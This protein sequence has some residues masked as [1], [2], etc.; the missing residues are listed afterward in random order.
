[1]PLFGSPLAAG[2]SRAEVL[3]RAN[4]QLELD[5]LRESD[6]ERPAERRVVSFHATP[7]SDPEEAALATKRQ[8]LRLD[9][10]D[11]FLEDIGAIL[12]AQGLDI[13]NMFGRRAPP[14]SADARKGVA[15]STSREEQPLHSKRNSFGGLTSKSTA[16]L[17]AAADLDSKPEPARRES[18]LAVPGATR[19]LKSAMKKPSATSPTP[20]ARPKSYFG[21]GSLPD[22]RLEP[23]PQS[24]IQATAGF[25]ESMPAAQGTPRRVRPASV[26][27]P[28]RY[29]SHESVPSL[30][31]DKGKG[32]V[33]PLS[34]DCTRTPSPMVSADGSTPD[35]SEAGNGERE[36]SSADTTPR[37]S[38]AQSHEQAKA[39]SQC[40]EDGSG[41]LRT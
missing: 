26:V 31:P 41:E 39:G 1:M 9:N 7:S 23:D 13:S 33:R 3:K 29:F 5:R 6:E 24:I 35:P 15:F 11:D 22:R 34:N 17:P 18:G 32:P 21:H 37:S 28:R 30:R 19:R 2:P 25:R 16:S 10:Y 8:D 14:D 36:Q 27:Q 38:S 4:S 40:A 20:P 12:L